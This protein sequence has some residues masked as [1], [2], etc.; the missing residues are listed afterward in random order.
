[1]RLDKFLK[2]SRLIKRRTLAKEACDHG[3]VWVNGKMAK[4]AAEINPGDK[5]TIKMGVKEQTVEV[6]QTPATIRSE[7][8]EH[9]YKVITT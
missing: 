5:L 4:A 3:K 6:L 7:Q 2:V 9:L 8:A 1:M